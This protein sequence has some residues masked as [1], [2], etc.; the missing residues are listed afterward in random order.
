[1][2]QKFYILAYKK[3]VD[4]KQK[5]Y[6]NSEHTWQEDEKG[7]IDIFAMNDNTHNGPRCIVC[8]YAECWHCRPVPPKEC[9][10]ENGGNSK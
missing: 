7:K 6:L 1:M 10:G 2:S 4:E 8:D 5:A 3:E 9:T